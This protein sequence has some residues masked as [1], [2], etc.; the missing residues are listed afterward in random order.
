MYMCQVEVTRYE[1]LEEAA[2]ELKMKH[3]L[4]ES[5]SQWDSTVAEWMQVATYMM[6]SRH[7]GIGA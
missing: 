3:L 4:W 1:E 7:R 6:L 2:A 5:L